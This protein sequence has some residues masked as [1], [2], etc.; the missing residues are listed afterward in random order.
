MRAFAPSFFGDGRLSHLA[1]STAAFR[2]SMPRGSFMCFIR[3]STGSMPAAAASSSMN[4]S[5]AYVFCIRPGVRI[6]EG[7]NGV[8]SSR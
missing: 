5:L 6:H 2:T 7:R 1:A 4:V 8:V 3:N